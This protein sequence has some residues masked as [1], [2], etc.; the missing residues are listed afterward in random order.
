MPS[1]DRGLYESLIT[2]TLEASLEKLDPRH[3]AH[4][5]GLHPAE[6]PDRIALHLGRV[7]ERSL[8]DVPDE[9]RVAKGIGLAR[10]PVAHG[11]PRTRP[12][13]LVQ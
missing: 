6:T 13:A 12:P 9:E 1:P 8:M 2:D 11:L 5:R 10:L 4:R 3:V 7:I